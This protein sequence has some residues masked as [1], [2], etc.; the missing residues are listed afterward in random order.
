[1][2]Y[3]IREY[4]KDNFSITKRK[5]RENLSGSTDKIMLEIGKTVVGM[6]ME[7]GSTGEETVIMGNGLKGREG[8]MGSTFQ[9]VFFHL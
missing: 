9:R 1:M 4:I 2:K 5:E 7:F 3:L 6:V 8:A